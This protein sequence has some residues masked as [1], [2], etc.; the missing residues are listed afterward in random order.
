M[1]EGPKE[2]WA[3]PFNSNTTLL[4][5]QPFYL[6]YSSHSL[7]LPLSQPH[8]F[9]LLPLLDLSTMVAPYSFLHPFAQPSRMAIFTTIVAYARLGNY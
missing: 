8:L 7:E 1:W 4:I 3:F 6:F 5:S 9:S 2:N